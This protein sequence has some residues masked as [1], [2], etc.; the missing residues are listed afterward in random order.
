MQLQI[1]KYKFEIQAVFYLSL[2]SDL[3]TK[4]RIT[5]LWNKSI[6]TK[7]WNALAPFRECLWMSGGMAPYIFNLGTRHMWVMCFMPLDRRL[8]G[9]QSQLDSAQK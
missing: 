5:H 9:L 6:G 2:A 3:Y 8:G 4:I 1:V 7:V